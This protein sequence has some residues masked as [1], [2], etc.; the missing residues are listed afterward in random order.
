[1]ERGQRVAS[2]HIGRDLTRKSDLACVGDPLFPPVVAAADE[3]EAKARRFREAGG[4]R[5][6][7]L[8]SLIPLEANTIYPVSK[9]VAELGP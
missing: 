8:L 4:Y 3:A 5:L 2:H 6:L 9:R 1:M 7:G